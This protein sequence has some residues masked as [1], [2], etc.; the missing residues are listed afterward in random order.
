MIVIV[1]NAH[2]NFPELII[3]INRSTAVFVD[4]LVVVVQT[5]IDRSLKRTSRD[6]WT[7]LP[8][9]RVWRHRMPTAVLLLM[10]T[11]ARASCFTT[12]F[13]ETVATHQA[14]H[15]PLP[16]PPH[17]RHVAEELITGQILEGHTSNTSWCGNLKSDPR[18]AVKGTFRE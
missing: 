17:P 1:E 11:G 14:V 10:M 9:C 8:S 6:L 18:A 5:L 13:L 3:N 4:S 16:P 12:N 2:Y 7:L 15:I